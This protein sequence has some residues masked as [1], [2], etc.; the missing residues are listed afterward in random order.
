MK[1]KKRISMGNDS[2]ITK[3]PQRMRFHPKVLCTVNTDATLYVIV[4]ST[5]EAVNRVPV[6]TFG[7]H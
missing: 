1:Q 7:S 5:H 4:L 6:D 2:H 3:M